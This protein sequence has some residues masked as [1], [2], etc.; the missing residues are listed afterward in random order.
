MLYPPELRARM[1]HSKVYR[2]AR[3]AVLDIVRQRT[4]RDSVRPG[5]YRTGK[6]ASDLLKPTVP[7]GIA[8]APRR[9]RDIKMIHC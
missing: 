9:V 7:G 6:V 3:T 1:A 2:M 8:P 5:G 4:H